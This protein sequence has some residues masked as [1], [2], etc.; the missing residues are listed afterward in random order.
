[1]T[2]FARTG[3]TPIE[4]E[5]RTAAGGGSNA[6]AAFRRAVYT[7]FFLSRSRCEMLVLYLSICLFTCL[8]LPL[9]LSLTFAPALLFPFHSA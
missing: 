5:P 9:S 7:D 6:R 8:S 4:H 1:M 2:P 3:Y